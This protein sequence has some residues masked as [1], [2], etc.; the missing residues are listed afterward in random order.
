MELDDFKKTWTALDNRLK[1]NDFLK[2]SIILEIIQSKANKSVNK[3]QNWDM[4]NLV[5]SIVFIPV[6]WFFLE[7]A[8]GKLPLFILIYAIA[9]LVVSAIWYSYKMYGL[10]KV[11]LAKS[12]SD[13]IYHMNRYSLLMNWEKLIGSIAI[14]VLFIL[15]VLQYAEAKASLFLWIVLSCAII[16]G[17]LFEY[18]FYRR[19]YDKNIG[20]AL[21]SLEELK[22]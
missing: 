7:H 8:K 2:E 3:L 21:K 22:N 4:F 18:W 19:V 9:L 6:L 1:E 11:D 16:L 5:G 17:V 13:N 10:M 15:I 12:V 20:S 14:S